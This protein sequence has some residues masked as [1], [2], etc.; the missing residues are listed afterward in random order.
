LALKRELKEHYELVKE[1]RLLYDSKKKLA[2]TEPDNYMSL[3]ID[4]MDQKK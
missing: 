3:V 4:G 2:M 1:E